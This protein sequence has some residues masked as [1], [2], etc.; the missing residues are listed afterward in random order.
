MSLPIHDIVGIGFGPSNLAL[1]IVLEEQGYSGSVVFL[2]KAARLGW[3]PGMMPPGSDIRNNPLRDLV[4]PRN[5]RS[6][7]SFV[8]Y[9][10]ETGRL[11]EFL[12]LPAHYPLRKDYAAYAAWAARQFDRLVRYE[13]AV[14]GLGVETAADGEPIW[15]VR[16]AGRPDILGRSLVVG[17]G[18]TP[19][20]PEVFAPHLGEQVFHLVDYLPRLEARDEP[21]SLAVIGSSQSAVELLLDLSSRYPRARTL[22]IH[23]T[24]GFRLKDTNPFS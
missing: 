14:T 22:A 10:H 18:R 23:R 2:E 15:R 3:Y 16:I 5:P 17:P 6:R 7:Y 19:R 21:R 8:N 20:I 9:L 11:F 24:F 1:A 4:T 13:H 12:N